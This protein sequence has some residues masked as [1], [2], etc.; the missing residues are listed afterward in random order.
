MK[1]IL[2][3]SYLLVISIILS[4]AAPYRQPSRGYRGFVDVG[5]TGSFNKL[6]DIDS[7]FQW[8][9]YDY[10]RDT[11]FYISTTHG[12]Q[13]NNHLFVGAGASWGCNL[14]T[15]EHPNE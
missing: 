5:V 14:Y 4:N 8:E 1:S 15:N 12:Y 2:I 13:F 6:A 11:Y 3:L 7:R 9:V 10:S